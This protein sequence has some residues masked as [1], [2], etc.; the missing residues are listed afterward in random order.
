MNKLSK[1]FSRASKGLDSP[2]VTIEIHI[3]G[4]LPSFSIVGLPETSVR[5][6]KDRVRSAVMNSQFKFP[7]GR[8]TVSLAPANLP[9]KGGRYDLPIAIGVLLASEQIK[10]IIDVKDIEFYGELG[11]NGHIRYVEGL[12]P[13][14]IAA[15]DSNNTVIIPKDKSEQYS[16]VSDVNAYKADHLLKV[17]EFLTTNSGIEKLK[18]KPFN[19]KQIHKKDFFQVKGQQ[20]AK[21]ALE[22]ASA[23]NHNLLLIGPPGA[24]K[25]MLAERITSIMPLL[26]DEKALQCAAIYSVAD[27]PINLSRI[28]ACAFRSPHHSSSSVALVGGGSIPRPGEISLAHEGV[29]FLDELT[30]FPRNVLEVLRQPLENGKIHLSRASQQVTFPAN[31]QLIAAMN[32]CPCGFYGDGSDKC[33]CSID[34]IERYKNK[35]SGPL[36]DRIDMVLNVLPLPKEIVLEQNP[37]NV[38]SSDII[39]ERVIKAQ[40][41]QLKRQ[42]KLNKKLESD[43]IEKIVNLNKQNKQML[44]DIID[45]LN[46]SMRSYHSILKIAVTI[47]DL[48]G[49]KTIDKTHIAEAASYRRFS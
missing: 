45:K 7:N 36:L 23:G 38:D 21:R 43:E 34:Q 6:S 3:S 15:K 9:K 30:E 40:D 31:F 24:G 16:L 29:L 48:A 20:Q 32:P 49:S 47:A 22:I 17:C 18:A 41:I 13:A 5:E 14:V 12:L 19:N 37:K 44:S 39:R 26:E 33:H 42:G 1:L 4:G 46:L 2:L 10:P 35:I 11:L 28:R 8:I 25:T 27:K